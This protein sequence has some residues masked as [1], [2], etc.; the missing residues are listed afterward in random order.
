MPR[1]PQPRPADSRQSRPV[2]MIPVAEIREI[3]AEGDLAEHEA[4]E[5]VPSAFLEEFE[6]AV[7]GGRG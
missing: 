6:P 2:P 5:P 7:A 1:Q 3:L 4:M